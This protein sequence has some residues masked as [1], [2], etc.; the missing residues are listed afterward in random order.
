M[1]HDGMF[2]PAPTTTI[3]K[4]KTKGDFLDEAK[5]LIEGDRAETYGDFVE[6][7]RKI[8]KLWAVVLGINITT[9]QVLMCMEMVKVGRKIANPDHMD[10]HVDSMGYAAL[11]A[12]LVER[13]KK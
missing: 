2:G 6:L 9:T 12:E 3:K 1:K 10:N 11:L 7:H 13:N 5:R 4:P 8:G